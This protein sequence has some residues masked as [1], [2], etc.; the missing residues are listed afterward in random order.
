MNEVG[1]VIAQA[2]VLPKGANRVTRVSPGICQRQSHTPREHGPAAV[3]V[4]PA[5][6]VYTTLY[7][8]FIL[9]KQ[10]TTD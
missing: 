9:T 7:E 5:A 1:A 4:G 10:C 3:G 6:C 2:Q 8:I